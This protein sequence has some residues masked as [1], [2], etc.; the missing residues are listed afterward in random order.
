MEICPSPAPSGHTNCRL[1]IHVKLNAK[2]RHLPHTTA[3]ASSPTMHHSTT[4]KAVPAGTPVIACP[5]V[6]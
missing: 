6:P 4:I 1:K 2:E 5:W 3:H